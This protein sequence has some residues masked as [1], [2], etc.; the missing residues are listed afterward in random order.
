MTAE[1]IRVA[2]SEWPGL[3]GFIVEANRRA[4][5]GGVHCLHAQHGDDVASH[6]AELRTLSPDAAAFWVLQES[7]LTK[8]LL[9]CEF[10][11]ALQRAWV[12]G[13]LWRDASAMADLLARAMPTLEAALPG[14]RHFDAFPTVA[15][16][17]LNAWLAAAGYAPQQVHT[18]LRASIDAE[19]SSDAG[20]V[21]RATPAD[22]AVVSRLHRTLFESTYIGEADL[23]RAI[24]AADCAL[25][26]ATGADGSP[27]G[28]LYLQD[29]PIE[30]EA[31]IDYL[32]IDSDR[33]GRGLGSALLGAASR[34][35]AASGRAHLALTVREDRP[36]AHAL[37]RRHGFVEISAARHWRRTVAP[38]TA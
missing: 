33:R 4:D 30:Q 38:P 7:G 10:D 32:G 20:P 34:W 13:P 21:R 27:A 22:I 11:P 1:L 9:G 8:A 5:G 6:A 24:D 26:V 2:A 12:R 28:Y 14:I 23:V 16:E 31:Y 35:G 19:P 3:A 15:S 29:A 36:G 17:P 18:L 25:F 37:Y